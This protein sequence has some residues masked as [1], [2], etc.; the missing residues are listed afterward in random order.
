MKPTSHCLATLLITVLSSS[1]SMMAQGKVVINEIMQSNVDFIFVGH[2]FPDSWVELYNGSSTRVR[3]D[4]YRIGASNVYSESFRIA[5]TT[6]FIE[7]GNHLLLY[8]DKTTGTPFHY[9]F[10][11]EADKGKLFLFNNMGV[12]I[13]S[14]IYKSMP[15]P[16]VAYGRITDGGNQW[17]YELLPT[18]GAPNIN[19]GSDEVL[20]EPL[21]SAEGHVMGGPETVTISMPWGVP[22]DTRIYLTLDGSEPTWESTSDTL[23]VLNIHKSTVVRAKLLSKEMLPIRSTTHSYIFHPRE[24]SLPVVSIATDSTYLFSRE[25]GI[26]S[27]D[28]TDGKPNYSYDWRRPANFEYF[29]TKDGTTVF[30]Q[31]GEMAVGGANSRKMPQKSIKCYAKKRFGKKN[32]NGNLWQDKPEVTKVKSFLLRNGGQNCKTARI[33]DAV[34]QRFFGTNLDEIDWQAYEP[35]IVYINGEY[36]GVCG[37]RE[38]SNEDYLSSNYDIDEDDVEIATASNYRSTRSNTPNF[39]NFRALY[40][41]ADVTYEELSRAMNIDNFTNVFIAECY[42]SNTDFPRGN[43]YIWMQISTESQWQWILKDLDF[44]SSHNASWNMF[45][46]MFGTD[47]TEDDEYELSHSEGINLTRFLYEKMMSFPEFRSHFIAT[48]ATYLG[49]FLRPDICIPIVKQMD[50]EILNEIAPTFA[51]YNNM[52]TLKKHNTAV[53]QLCDYIAQRPDYVYRQMADYFSL[54]DVIPINIIADSTNVSNI[55][56]C[57]IPVRTSRF[58]GAWFTRFP[59]SIEAIGQNATT[60]QMVVSHADGRESTHIYASPA[61]QPDLS[62]CAPGDS[63]TFIA[64]DA[65][66][67]DAIATN[68]VAG[69]PAIAAIYD[70]SGKRLPKMQNGLNIIV[71]TNGTR[72]IISKQE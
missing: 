2:D 44:V 32:F 43:V 62:S 66:G 41:R 64:T 61:I 29:R 71:Y 53:G 58:D 38:R 55:T 60:W 13:D 6:E 20:P 19:A 14:V 36:K 3:I 34:L 70:M 17:Q 21:F 35:V 26:L 46:Y 40:N 5:K 27:N 22:E 57:N 15:A 50:N 8:C 39:N 9:N 37:L 7:P 25:E 67:E 69:K 72:Q 30:N 52:S 49:D 65:N 54:G 23:F 63:I 11:L 10:N 12:P 47:N 16:N 31:C 28:S 1:G 56:I 4:N 42:S 24:T 59:L 68:H 45:K 33:N 18:P 51:A 48:Y